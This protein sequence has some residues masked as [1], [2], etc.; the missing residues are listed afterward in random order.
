M[1]AKNL[2]QQGE[3][4][5]ELPADDSNA[6][7]EPRM[8]HSLKVVLVGLAALIAL[9]LTIN[10]RGPAMLVGLGR[11][12]GAASAE[13]KSYESSGTLD[14]FNK[15]LVRVHDAYVDP[16]RIDPK[17]MLIAAL[18]SVQKHVAEVLIE[19]HPE[20]NRVLVRVDTASREFNIETVDAAWSLA[21]KM[22]EIFQ[23]IVQNL[24]PGT[25]QQA[26]RDI[27]YA[28]T[29]GMLS[30][31][32]PHSVLLDP[33]TYNDMKTS[34]RG[35]FG[36][37]GIV[38]G[39]R[40]SA[41]TVIRPMRNT[42]AW[43]AGVRRGDR[44]VRIEKDATDNMALT[45][46]VD[47][48]RGD[49]GTRVEL[50]IEHETEH[51]PRH[52]TLTRA[53]IQV[54]S[55]IARVLKTQSGPIGYIR[56]SQFN[57]KCD[58]DLHQALEEQTRKNQ[59]RGLILDLRGDPG[60]LLDKAI[61]VADEFLDAGTIVTTVGFANKQREEKRATPAAQPHIPMAVLV[62][63]QSASAS[64]IVAGALK[65]LDRALI[66]GS[67][68]F[69]KGSVQVL[70]DNEDG[71]ALKLTIAQYLT[72]GDVSIQSVGIS[73][74]VA[75]EPMRV[76]KNRL[77]LFST[78]KGTREQDLDAHLT[79]QN[80]RNADK[81]VESLRY[82]WTDPRKKAPPK[83]KGELLTDTAGKDGNAD[84]ADDDEEPIDDLVS[85]ED[86]SFVEDYVIQYARDMLG[87]ARG[88]RRRDMLSAAR[89]F[90]TGKQRE[91][92]GRLIESL[93]KFGVDF[94]PV[95]PQSS[96]PRLVAT[97]TTDKAEHTARAGETMV[98]KITVSN[99]GGG[100]AG[101]VRAQL[102]SDNYL[103]EDREFVFG[104][105]GPGESRSWAIPVKVPKDTLPRLDVVK[106]QFFEENGHS[107]Q[108]QALQVKLNGLPRPRF[109]YS[110]QLIDEGPSSNG[111]GL[112]SR[113][114]A[115]RL[116]VN[117]QN[118]GAGRAL[119]PVGLLRNAAGEGSL[120]SVN[121]GRFEL[122]EMAPNEKRTLDFTFE[123]GSK[124]S[125]PTARL[126]LQV[127]DLGMHDGV[128]D[129][130]TFPIVD[131]TPRAQESR[132]SLVVSKEVEVRTGAS[133]N[134]PIIARAR[135]GDRFP[136]TGSFPGFVR[137]EL[138]AG[139]P[140]YISSAA[141]QIGGPLASGQATALSTLVW[142][143][144][145]PVLEV[146]TPPLAVKS[147]KLQIS[148]TAHDNERVIDAYV[149]V[150][151]RVAKIEHRKVFYRSNRKAARQSEMRFDADVPLWPGV[152]VVT[153]VARQSG[154]VMSSQALIVNRL[155]K[156]QEAA[157][158]EAH[159]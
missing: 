16:T 44:I 90:F 19:A 52:L 81:P 77:S 129:K 89:D 83:P 157:V 36:G 158:A 117:V 130:L 56:L 25:D 18:D 34:T 153:V 115:V 67:R 106:A 24:L 133:A 1:D 7:A 104:R 26:I 76:E 119:R 62:D 50:W 144:T 33:Q 135:P 8:R 155:G 142:Q 42:P 98:F 88:W 138:E 101:Q 148:A 126:E 53:E 79:S 159:P 17:Q 60:G 64:E 140:G 37:L 65:N 105:I 40:K 114:E 120:I 13:H 110:Y 112:L 152:N 123:V 47:R 31:L 43:D 156:E 20:Q 137:V 28:A 6:T 69:G 94:S 125:E 46:A 116:R 57:Q 151:N 124:F 3:K 4:A 48:L 111:D 154:Q 23:F 84:D 11:T 73:P 10:H 97:V 121:K 45:D 85:E 149:V 55:I 68:T 141:G 9:A 49:P 72:P 146:Q 63:G 139:R 100:I 122:S 70:Y 150:S 95:G 128:T 61:K 86:D 54:P 113:G 107:P 35:S 58:E 66:I 91:Q 22:A 92:Q 99:Q 147:G 109:A 103:Y 134:A 75:L 15:T 59:I 96:P 27:E 132:G 30:T 71:S 145:P 38:I 21:P 93:R 32:D 127:Y 78:Y 143:V 5:G 136:S 108:P 74:D 102:K 118:V 131:A 39:I 14:T 41:L 29:N 87:S 51:T 2:H 80:A 82:I 12:T